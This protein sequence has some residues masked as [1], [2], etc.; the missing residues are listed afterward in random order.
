MNRRSRCWAISVRRWPERRRVL[1]DIRV[2][3]STLHFL[4]I[5][6]DRCCVLIDGIHI[7]AKLHGRGKHKLVEMVTQLLSAPSDILGVHVFV[8]EPREQPAVCVGVCVYPE[9]VEGA[10]DL[11]L[12]GYRADRSGCDQHD[13]FFEVVHQVLWKLL[14]LFMHAK[15]NLVD[16]RHVH[17]GILGDVREFFF[18]VFNVL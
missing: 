5:G 6:C 3:P 12:A 14:F 16:L 9:L 10:V 11:R 13:E 18:V 1:Q 17:V 2:R 7:D 15:A 8:E 4:Q